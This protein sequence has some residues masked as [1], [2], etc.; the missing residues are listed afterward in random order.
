MRVAA[1]ALAFIATVSAHQADAQDCRLVSFG[2]IPII[3]TPNGA[4]Q[5]AVTLNG[6]PEKVELD[7]AK[8]YSEISRAKATELD[9][10]VV[11]QTR[12]VS[13]LGHDSNSKTVSLGTLRLGTADIAGF[14]ALEY[15]NPKDFAG[16]VLGTNMLRNFLPEFDVKQGVVRL[17][18]KQHC[19]DKLVYW[20]SEY[21]ALKYD[22]QDGRL[23]VD[24]K[25]NGRDGHA[26]FAPGLAQSAISLDTADASNLPRDGGG[27]L[28][29][30][31]FGG[32]ALHNISVTTSA[33]QLPQEYGQS[34]HM[35]NHRMLVPIDIK[36]G[37]DVLKH[38]RYIMDFE[39]K[40]VYFTVA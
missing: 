11:A 24:V 16:I 35:G 1:V 30:L 2:E 6:K 40:T 27:K 18:G 28:Q 22:D 36:L 38:L 26:I 20:S 39:S 14:Q 13:E 3:Q 4:G 15:D 8:S 19:A 10:L 31:E 21:L 23:L 5:L 25:I 34:S 7:F 9:A 29:S 12:I 33:F 32:I 17:F 37:A